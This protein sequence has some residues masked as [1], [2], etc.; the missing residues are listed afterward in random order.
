V[1]RG[2]ELPGA[3]KPSGD[4]GR[5]LAFFFHSSTAVP[6]VVGVM[7]IVKAAYP[8][9]SQFNRRSP[10]F[11]SA[12][13]REDP[14]WVQVDV[15]YKQTFPRPLALEAIRQLPALGGMVLVQNSRLSV[16]PVT[17]AEWAFILRRAS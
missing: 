11:D 4:A 6:A 16:Q 9:P 1:G 10:F 5:D 7:A 2:T 13:T 14:R 12:S 8:D 3:Q 15:Q 17:P